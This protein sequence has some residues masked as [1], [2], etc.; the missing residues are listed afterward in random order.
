MHQPVNL[1][2]SIQTAPQIDRAIRQEK[3]G[4]I[5]EHSRLIM[6]PIYTNIVILQAGEVDLHGE[7]AT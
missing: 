3:L 7:G 1:A 2:N 6:E 5:C 4:H